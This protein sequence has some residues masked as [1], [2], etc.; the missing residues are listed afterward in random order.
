MAVTLARIESPA[1]F[2]VK[3]LGFGL[4]APGGPKSAPEVLVLLAASRTVPAWID[5]YLKGCQ[6]DER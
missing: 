1:P 4:L 6:K 2:L 5:A 3:F